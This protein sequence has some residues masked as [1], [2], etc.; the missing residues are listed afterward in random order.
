MQAEAVLGNRKDVMGAMT[1]D[2]HE[3]PLPSPS[4]PALSPE[5]CRWGD[6]AT[7]MSSS[8]PPPAPHPLSSP[9]SVPN[10]YTTEAPVSTQ[11]SIFPFEDATD[12]YTGKLDHQAPSGQLPPSPTPSSNDSPSTPSSLSLSLPALNGRDIQSALGNCF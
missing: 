12:G 4:P 9:P 7:P 6:H 10:R 5:Q 3:L 2:K 11:F 1:E 8:F